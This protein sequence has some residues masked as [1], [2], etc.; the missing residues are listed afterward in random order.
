M[1]II[2]ENQ[3][4]SNKFL[5]PRSVVGHLVK[6]SPTNNVDNRINITQFIVASFGLSAVASEQS[7]NP[8]NATQH[9]VEIFYYTLYRETMQSNQNIPRQLSDGDTSFVSVYWEWIC[10]PLSSFEFSVVVGW[11]LQF[12]WWLR[13][14]LESS[15]CAECYSIATSNGLSATAQP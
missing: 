4:Q 6:W 13:F 7:S 8:H 9:I 15:V 1:C 2:R 11:W 5:R 12:D 3:T 14:W 10:H